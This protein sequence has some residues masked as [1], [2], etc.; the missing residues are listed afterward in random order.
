[1][2]KPPPLVSVII[3]CYNQGEYLDE[4]IGSLRSQTYSPI[5]IILIDDGSTDSETQRKINELNLPNLKK[6]TTRNQGLANTRNFGIAQAKGTYILPLDAD[7]KIHSSYIEKAVQILETKKNIT[8]VYC[9]AMTFGAVQGYWNLPKFSFPE[10]L[11]GNQVFCSALFRRNDFNKTRGYNPNMRY[12]W[13][14]WD[15]WLSFVSL[16]AEFYLIPEILF[17]Y[18][19]KKK[20]MATGMTL[21]KRKAM[22]AQ[23]IRNHPDLFINNIEILMNDYWEMRHKIEKL[24]SFFVVRIF[25]KLLLKIISQKNS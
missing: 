14:D 9:Q 21:E 24:N 15:L 11:L 16:K 12:G 5:E 18:R 13:E 2:R 4:S 17:Y 7:D 8:V 10:I 1:M 19:V 20:S 23:L 6:F 25:K 22:H 3:P